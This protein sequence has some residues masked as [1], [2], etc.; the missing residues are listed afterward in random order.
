[1]TSI[2]DGDDLE[3]RLSVMLSERAAAV[4]VDSDPDAILA[5]PFRSGGRQSGRGWML[6]A[7]ATIVVLGLG[8]LAVA[9]VQDRDSVQ[10][11]TVP[12]TPAPSTNTATTTASVPPVDSSPATLPA[13]TTVPAAPVASVVPDTTAPGPVT[14]GWVALDSRG[15][16]DIYLVRPGEDARRL[17]VAGSD[18]TQAACPTW[19]PD[20]TRLLF[21]RVTGSSDITLGDAE[22]VIV[23]VGLDGAAGA[24]TVIALDGF[25]A[26]EGFDPHPCGVWAPDGRWVALRGPGDVWVIDTQ[27]SAIR[28]LPDLRPIDFEWRPGTDELAIAGDMGPT[29]SSDWQSTPVTVYSV[30]TGELSQLESIRASQLTWSPDGT[31]IAFARVSRVGSGDNEHDSTSLWLVDADGTNERPLVADPFNANHGV[32]PVWSPTGD[33]IAYQRICC[34]RSEGHEVVLVDVADGAQTVIAPPETAG[35]YGTTVRWYPWTV[36]WSPDGTTLLYNAWSSAPER[37]DLL[38]VSA[39]TPSDVTVL[40]ATGAL[41][42]GVHQWVLIENWGRQP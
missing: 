20:G 14:N 31:T 36:T 39:D 4:E 5:Q 32:G 18:T 29:R 37:D 23:P 40:T 17:E 11:G 25:G 33:R 42:P 9:A 34:G 8:L 22:L 1:M 21:G 28:R 19:S 41:Q 13:T 10:T 35:P 16:G 15:T 12:P 24:P 27:T 3:R 2:F 38:V 7:A 30:S 6:V 26:L